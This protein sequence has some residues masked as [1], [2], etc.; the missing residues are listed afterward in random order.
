MDLIDEK[1]KEETLVVET[2]PTIGGTEASVIETPKVEP[3][4]VEAMVTDIPVVENP[5]T[6]QQTVESFQNSNNG[7]NFGPPATGTEYI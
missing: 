1:T 2:A 5:A 7:N 6:Q 3:P 4:T